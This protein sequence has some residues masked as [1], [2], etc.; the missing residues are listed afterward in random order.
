MREALAEARKDDA[1]ASARKSALK[2]ARAHAKAANWLLDSEEDLSL[3][4]ALTLYREALLW[5]VADDEAARRA[6]AAT[7]D[8]SPESWQAAAGPASEG[9]RQAA[10]EQLRR[11]VSL[12]IRQERESD[13]PALLR[14][15]EAMRA[16]LHVLMVEAESAQGGKLRVVLHKRR[17]RMRF[18]AA[19]LS[20]VVSA[21]TA[22]SLWLF[23]PNDLARDKPWH[24]SSAL[25][26]I[27]TAKV[28]FH[29]IEEQSPWFEID[30]LRPTSVRRL[31]V[32]N[33]VDC[34]AER[35]VPLLVE[36]T[37]DRSSWQQ[38][39]RTDAPFVEWTPSF[40]P[41]KARYVRL[42]VPRFTT[43]HLEAV[44]VY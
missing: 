39:A 23:L 12:Q 13:S 37:N 16:G 9:Q 8:A 25:P 3:A 36:V 22:L 31:H 4:P 43:F 10:Q 44:K 40:A 19:V 11:C 21:A 20:A 1:G 18:A 32:T 38:V 14:E 27:Y 30:L 41:V 42:R 34:C 33:R 35:A 17:R 24:T 5:L 29:T 6:L 28:L 2:C 7:I 15:I 26:H